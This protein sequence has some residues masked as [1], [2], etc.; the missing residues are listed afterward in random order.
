MDPA[1][2]E[3]LRKQRQHLSRQVL[4]SDAVVQF[5]YQED[6]LTA[7]HVE[8]IECEATN[9]RKTLR[10]LD[11][12]PTRGPRAFPALLAALEADF[13]WVRTGLLE[14]L[15]AHRETG[16]SSEDDWHIPA[17]LLGRVP[18]DRELSRLASLLGP[19]S[20]SLLLQLGLSVGA[21]FRCR[22]DH[23]HSTHGQVLAG[24]VTWRQSV[25]KAA[26]VGRL[27]DSLQAA[28]I[29]PSVLGEVFQ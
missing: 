20:E 27:L 12:L 8:E 7:S 29:H 17:A 11:V 13:P 18:S 15:E 1:H 22:A 16:P 10:L 25:G 28:E 3:L 9:Q 23:P 21:L 6:I 5:L 26:T 19:E 4:V 24:L 2:R 14:Q